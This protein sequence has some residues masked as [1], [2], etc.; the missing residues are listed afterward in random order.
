MGFCCFLQHLLFNATCS[1]LRITCARLVIVTFCLIPFCN[2]WVYK[3]KIT[4]SF[5]YQVCAA[6]K[7]WISVVT[8]SQKIPKV[9]RRQGCFAP[10]RRGKVP[11]WSRI[12]GIFFCVLAKAVK[13]IQ[14]DYRWDVL[15]DFLSV[16][17]LSYTLYVMTFKRD[18]QYRYIDYF[19]DAYMNLMK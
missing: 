15:I 14:N 18:I 2:R 11:R 8:D 19:R 7:F 4:L 10:S 12:E 16:M 1:F 17:F 6:V 13:T 9:P 5:R 3:C